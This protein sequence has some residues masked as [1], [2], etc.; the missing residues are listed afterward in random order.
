MI[1]DKQVDEFVKSPRGNV[2]ANHWAIEIALLHRQVK[3][4]ETI[5]GLLEKLASPPM[6]MSAFPPLPD[7]KPGP[8]VFAPG[9]TPLN[10]TGGSDSTEKGQVG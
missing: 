5:V 8:V 6:I 9:S 2:D 10:A 4:L 1:T 7:M 3:A